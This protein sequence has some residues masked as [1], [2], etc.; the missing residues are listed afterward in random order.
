MLGRRL[1]PGVTPSDGAPLSRPSFS[2]DV[3]AEQ[4]P[5]RVGMEAPALNPRDHVHDS[6]MVVT[7]E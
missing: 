3:S 7:L 6:A 4:R 5:D 2:A 1:T